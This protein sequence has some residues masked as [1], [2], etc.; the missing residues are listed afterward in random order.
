M[1]IRD[2][3]YPIGQA[4]PDGS[5]LVQTQLPDG[6]MSIIVDPGAWTN[7]AG[8]RWVR[9]MAVK[10]AQHN[11]MPDQV[12]LNKPLDVQGVGHG[13]QSAQWAARMPIAVTD[14]E[15]QTKEQTFE[16]PTL[17]GEGGADVPALLGLRS[18]RAKNAILE[19]A[20]GKECLTFPGEGGYKIDWSPGTVHLPLTVA[21]SGHYVI[22]CD[23][24]AQ[25]NQ[26]QGGLTEERTVLLAQIEEWLSNTGTATS[27]ATPGRTPPPPPPP[28]RSRH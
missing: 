1:C 18:M 6:R 20:P 16:V 24:Y 21:P 14:R 27:S 11:K 13:T 7:L 10:A 23:S 19:M 22:P 15:G 12:K 5:F 2:R 9:G 25:L 3:S 8:G 17:E 28:P 4:T 26:T